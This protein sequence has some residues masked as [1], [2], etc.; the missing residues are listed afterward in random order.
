MENL[1]FQLFVVIFVPLLM[2]L[3]L[4]KGKSRIIITFLLIGLYVCLFAGEMNGWLMEFLG[5]NRFYMTISV[6]PIVEEILKGLPVL[7]FAFLFKPDRQLLLE[8]AMTCGIGFA[9]QENVYLLAGAVNQVSMVWALSRG[10]G[11]GLMHG[12]CTLAI[13][14][15]LSFIKTKK[16]LFYTGTFALLLTAIIYHASFNLLVQSNYPIVGLILPLST[17]IPLMFALRKRGII[18]GQAKETEKGKKEK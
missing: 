12:I 18:G 5:E 7:I 16:K 6:T 14:V 13:G 15:G 3:Y 2:V 11:A 8:C 1:N 4:L 10:I 17:Y 9:I